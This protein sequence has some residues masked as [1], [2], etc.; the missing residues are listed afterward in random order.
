M[1]RTSFRSGRALIT[2]LASLLLAALALSV[3]PVSQA[4]GPTATQITI[5]NVYTPTFVPP[6]TPGAPPSYVVQD[7]PFNVDITLDAPLSYYQTKQLRLTVIAGPDAGTLDLTFAVAP[8]AT[9][10]TVSGVVLPNFGNGVTIKVAV[11]SAYSNV[12]PGTA[13][14][15]VLKTSL[16][17]PATS[18][19][20]G[21]GGG[22]GPGV[23]CT[24]TP[25]DPVC[26]DLRLA[27]SAGV[28]SRQLLS[29]GSC[30][31]LCNVVGSFLQVLVDI[32]PAVYNKF[33]PIEVVA[34][35]DKTLCPG[36]GIKTYKVAVQL[37]P[38]S[39]L[40]D[41]PA[42]A[43]KGIVKTGKFCVDYVQSKRNN[44]GDLLLMVLLVDD[45]KIIFK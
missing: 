29:Q 16:W 4:T 19:L 24:P 22:G 15:E 44:A 40:T 9:T 7:V 10:A 12:A 18:T 45:A 6:D 5:A 23:A 34:K 33:N 1:P 32:D 41:A 26:G 21:F 38:T 42:C 8:G 30:E 36:K 25:A 3:A 28:L 14:F 13:T 17:A 39:L 35:C 27:E 37:T 31:G 2:V 43:K 11:N 20:T